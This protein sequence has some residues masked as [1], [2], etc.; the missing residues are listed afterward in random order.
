MHYRLT[1]SRNAMRVTLV[2]TMPDRVTHTELRY[3]GGAPWLD[4]LATQGY[5]FSDT[6]AERIPTVGRLDE[7]LAHVGLRPAPAQVTDEDLTTARDLRDAL[8]A[9]ALAVLDGKG[10]DHA[11]LAMVV[12]MADRAAGPLELDAR[13][14][15]VRR[16]P[17]SVD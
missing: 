12:G 5:P 10:P 9:V 16:P 17:R 13:P 7:F 14:R 3:D 4:F 6:P 8:R 11:A 1:R 2:S 15:L